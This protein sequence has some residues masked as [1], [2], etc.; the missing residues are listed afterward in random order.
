MAAGS[1][2]IDLLANTGSFETDTQRA[3]NTLKKLTAA[4]KETGRSF[5]ELGHRF[6]SLTNTWK[7]A[8]DAQTNFSNGMQ[9]SHAAFRGS[10]QIIQQ[11]SYQ[12]TDFIM[13]VNGGVD[14]VRAFGQQAPQLLG[15]FGAAGAAV[16]V[17]VALGAGIAPMI[18]NWIGASKS[19]ED[20]Q[21]SLENALSNVSQTAQS[22]DMSKMVEQFNAADAVVRRGIINLIE[23]RKTA[24][25]LAAA[26]TEKALQTQLKGLSAPGFM[27]RAL[28]QFEGADL[29]I[30]VNVAK[31]FF[32]EVRS[33]T[34]EASILAQKYGS[35]LLKGNDTAKQLAATLNKVA[36]DTQSAANAS[37]A[38]SKFLSQAK[39]AGETGMIPT[40]K[41]K[42]GKTSVVKEEK[43]ELDLYIASLEKANVQFELLGEKRQYLDSL[44]DSPGIS[45]EIWQ[46]FSDDLD[47]AAGGL[48]KIKDNAIKIGPTMEQAFGQAIQQGVSGLVDVFFEA[49]Q[50]FSK[51]AA[52][53]MTQIAKMITQMMLLK[54]IEGGLK[55]IGFGSSSGNSGPVGP[56]INENAKGNA[57]Y[58]G[59]QKFANGG[60]FTNS[61][62]SRPTMF[63]YGGAFGSSAGVMGEA[64]PEAVMPLKRDSSG[65]L[66]VQGNQSNVSIVVNNNS[67]NA[68]ATATSKTDSFGNRQIEIMVADMVNKAIST[69]KTDGAMRNAY[70]IRRAGK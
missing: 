24:A 31:N 41:S 3:A 68:Q 18:M 25:E 2:I 63:A 12:V 61:I 53:F 5:E 65:R 59:I 58:N 6:D 15:A 52:N 48:Q 67:S 69:G 26:E 4:S 50:S 35:E 54:A 45:P 39:T 13:Q 55:Y 30:D 7:K 36:L 47:R 27:G 23:Y 17:F 64:G 38:M 33:G 70:N 56:V 1:V 40:N 66:G 29:G 46:K 37:S 62:V 28:G 11:T 51:F 16:G 10:N 9:R 42:G 22:F 20:T 34:S 49:N 19:L 60:A 21:K 8:N 57:F 44:K 14:A 32:A 43:S